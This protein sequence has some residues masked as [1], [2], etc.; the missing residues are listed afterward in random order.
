MLWSRNGNGGGWNVPR[1]TS[2]AVNT[3]D[4][5]TSEAAEA[6]TPTTRACAY[7]ERTNVA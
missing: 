6:S 5:G 7:G 2:A 1:S 4:P 3:C